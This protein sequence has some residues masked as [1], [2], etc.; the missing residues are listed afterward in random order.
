LQ[1]TGTGTVEANHDPVVPA[2]Q[3]M[4]RPTGE[5]IRA[6]IEP[7]SANIPAAQTLTPSQVTDT[8]FL[9]EPGLEHGA[10]H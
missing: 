9:N 3:E 1:F 6:V 5:G 4:P 10:P 8:S 7:L 2:F